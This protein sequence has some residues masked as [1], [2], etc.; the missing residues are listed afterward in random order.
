MKIKPKAVVLVSGGLDSCVTAAIANQS[1]GLSFLHANYGQRTEQKE[2]ASFNKIADYYNVKN[3]LIADLKWLKK[4]GGSSLTDDKV[5]IPNGNL[6]RKGIPSTYVPFRNAVLLSMAVSWAE[7]ISADFIFIGTVAQDIPNYPDTKPEFFRVFNK[8][9]R[10]GT[11]TAIGTKIVTPI[12][13]L[14]KSEVIKLGIKLNAPL[15][16]TW[17]CYKNNK[18]PCNKCDACIR[19]E[20]AFKI[21]KFKDPILDF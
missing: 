16:L 8:L 17:S 21:V 3:R 7:T 19:R 20:N 9:I 2:L 10:V 4:I 15:N 12:N 1:C 14:E 11:N 6:N 18:T 5:I 13:N